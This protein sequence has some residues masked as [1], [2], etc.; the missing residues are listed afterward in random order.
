MEGV[1]IPQTSLLQSWHSISMQ[2]IADLTRFCEIVDYQD[3]VHEHLER[4]NAGFLSIAASKC[5]YAVLPEAW[6]NTGG[7]KGNGGY[8]DIC[9]LD[10]VRDTSTLIECKWEQPFITSFVPRVS[11]NLSAACTEVSG[12]SSPLLTAVSKY[13]IIE[14]VGVA[15]ICPRFD[16]QLWPSIQTW[17]QNTINTLHLS[18]TYD[19]MAWNFSER[20]MNVQHYKLICPGIFM[21]CKI[22]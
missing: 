12:Y 15:F 3:A 7:K 13:R 4:A 9:I 14:K 18:V 5:G 16:G 8:T 21:I 11:A 22:V 10:P 6:S 19:I 1:F 17:L 2:W 20:L